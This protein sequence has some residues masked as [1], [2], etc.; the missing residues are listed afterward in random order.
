MIFIYSHPKPWVSEFKLIQECA[1]TSWIA[2]RDDVNITLLGKD[3]GTLEKCTEYGIN[4]CANIECNEY[5]TPLVS[6]IFDTITKRS[7]QD[8][9]ICYI[10]ADIVLSSDFIDTIENVKKTVEKDWLIVGK[11]TDMDA[12]P[13]VLL[14]G[15]S[16]IVNYA[17]EHGNDHGW[18]GI[19]YFIYNNASMFKFVYPFALGKFVWDQ[20]LIGNAYRRGI[21]TIDA[22]NSITAVHLNCAWYFKGNK[23]YNRQEIEDSEEGKRNANFDKYVK[24][25]L[26]GTTHTIDDKINIK[27]K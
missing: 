2:L 10:N 5:G 13:D 3:Y 27:K 23:T 18:D 9:I 6:S 8:D 22:S 1:I 11:R 15:T 14:Q 4:Y 12:S 25:I 21:C 19:D 24:N 20:W 7:N 17:K 16:A 26:D